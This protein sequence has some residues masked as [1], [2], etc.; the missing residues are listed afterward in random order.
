M[1]QTCK[2]IDPAHGVYAALGTPHRSDSVE[3]DTAALLEYLDQVTASGVDGLVLFGST[4][5]F[6]HFSPDERM[7]ATT[8]AIRRSRLPVL[9][10]VSHST[11]AGAVEIAEAAMEAGS[12]GLMLTPPYFYSYSEDQIFEFYSQFLRLA[13]GARVYLY[14]LPMF[15][16]PISP[17]LAVR[18]LET[19]QFT[20]IK[21]SSGNW[22]LF[23]TLNEVR[24]RISF[25]LLVGNEAIYLDGRLAGADGIISGVAAAVPELMVALDRVITARETE[26]AQHLNARLLEFLQYVNKFP[27]TLAI[28]QAAAARG[29]KLRDLALPL[30]S[31]TA[32][33][34]VKYKDWFR[35]WL[36]R[37]AAECSA[38]TTVRT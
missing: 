37:V 2:E 12:V 30:D 5:E 27:S 36:P 31:A 18:L 19:G 32:A 22:D 20:G 16:N 13:A 9:V 34:V 26:T 1:P 4:G 17:A 14:N 8:L 6:V 15:L 10:N 23:K 25:Q 11:L 21:D 3:V 28:R 38:A 7:R 33:E 35:G 29:W 24:Q